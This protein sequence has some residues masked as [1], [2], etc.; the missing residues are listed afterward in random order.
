MNEKIIDILVNAQ[1]NYNNVSLRKL[2]AVEEYFHFEKVNDED[3][4]KLGDDVV[5]VIGNPD[6]EFSLVIKD[7]DGKEVYRHLSSDKALRNVEFGIRKGNIVKEYK[8]SS[9][10]PLIMY[11]MGFEDLKYF[12]RDEVL[13]TAGGFPIFEDN[14]L[15][16]VA[17]ISGFKQGKD[18]NVFIEGLSLFLD[19]KIP[20]FDD[21]LV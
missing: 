7:M 18:F 5:K 12:D 8:H 20:V 19:K 2:R 9:I 16:Y 6:N 13:P 4:K 10:Y 21:Y 17:E 1:R 14:K 15:K 3:M 11:A